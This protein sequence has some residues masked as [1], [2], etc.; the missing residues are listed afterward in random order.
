[1]A[2]LDSLGKIEVVSLNKVIQEKIK[3]YIRENELTAGDKLP[4][5]AEL[6][7][8]IGVSRTAIR[9]A[10][11]GLEALGIID[12]QHGS[13]RYIRHID[14][15]EIIDDLAYTLELTSGNLRDLLEIRSVLEIEFLPEAMQCL[16][17]EDFIE[18]EEIL[19][20]M[21][22]KMRENRP[23]AE[24]DME[25]HQ[26]LFRHST[27]QLLKQLLDVFWRLFSE[28]LPDS[29]QVPEH[30]DAV[31]ER[32]HRLLDAV[33]EQDSHKAVSLL[34]SHFNDVK[35]RLKSE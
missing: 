15:S 8:R 23:F 10:L 33:R 21:E 5:E 9:E 3:N 4:T 18:L 28:A 1:M 27:N 22:Q 11:R 32:H 35:R 31:L 13:G 30:N 17:L 2:R 14:F 20:R 16:T 34:E 25:F 29:L 24:E 12:V 7:A 6:A 19:T 26:C